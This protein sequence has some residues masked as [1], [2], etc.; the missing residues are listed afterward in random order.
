M[1]MRCGGDL[2]IEDLRHH[3]VEMVSMLR[4]LLAGGARVEPDPKRPGFYEVESG[5]TVYYIHVSPVTGKILLLATWPS[6][7]AP[8]GAAQAA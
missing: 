6:Q 7:T 5:A 2:Q 8:L 4:K 3:P 1:V